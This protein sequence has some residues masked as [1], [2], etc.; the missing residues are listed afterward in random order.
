MNTDTTNQDMNDDDFGFVTPE[1]CQ[2][3]FGHLAHDPR[4]VAMVQAWIDRAGVIIATDGPDATEECVRCAIEEL[5][6]TYSQRAAAYVMERPELLAAAIKRGARI[7][8]DREG[9]AF[10]RARAAIAAGRTV[11]SLTPQMRDAWERGSAS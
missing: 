4:E 2:R 1:G 7:H 9:F 11:E 6:D 5:G 8:R 10:R 3:V